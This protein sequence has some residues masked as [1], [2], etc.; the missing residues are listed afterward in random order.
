MPVSIRTTDREF[1]PRE[2]AKITGVSQILQR[3]WRR[4]GYLTGKPS[5]KWSWFTLTEII[6]MYVMRSLSMAGLEISF[7]KDYAKVAVAPTLRWIE[8]IPDAVSCEDDEIPEA[9]KAPGGIRYLVLTADSSGAPVIHR[10][11]DIA[12]IADR[13]SSSDYAPHCT[14]IDCARIA[15]LI[16]EHAGRPLITAAAI[17]EAPAAAA[18]SP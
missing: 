16:A 13:L 4:R 6:R 3:T 12:T 2:T 8:Q 7:V 17:T 15:T 5:G 10:H 9:L 11:H 14:I 18:V 1:A